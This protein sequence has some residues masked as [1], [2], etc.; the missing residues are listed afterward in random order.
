MSPSGDPVREAFATAAGDE[1]HGAS[2]IERTLL[3]ALLESR[4]RWSEEALAD[5][6]IVLEDAHPA[7]ANLRAA[8][9]RLRESPPDAVEPWARG[10]LAE[11]D[12]LRERLAAGGWL[13]VSRA[14]RVVTVSRS[15]AVAAVLEGAARRGW[16]GEVVVLDGTPSGGGADQ[17]ER[18]AAAGLRVRSQPDAAAPVWLEGRAV[19]VCG[20]DAVAPSR[21][22]NATGTRALLELAAAAGRP[23]WMVADRA[24]DLPEE[25]LDDLLG[26]SRRVAEAG[27]GR[28]WGVLEAVPTALLS[29]RVDG[30]GGG[31]LC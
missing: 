11:L 7:M 16:T 22:V 2:E 4:D 29:G 31:A 26:R 8:A 9:I 17:A 6:A 15:S 24:K 30:R 19:V 23:A 14:A 3:G 12:D 20:A 1:R 18:L 28:R 21:F 5:G 25:I 13:V 10:R 27:P